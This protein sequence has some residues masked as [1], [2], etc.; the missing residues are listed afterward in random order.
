MKKLQISLALFIISI[1]VFAQTKL[2][3]LA[4]QG[5][6]IEV[7]AKTVAVIKTDVDSN[8][9]YI[10]TQK[11][12]A[13]KLNKD[14]ITCNIGFVQWVLIFSPIWLFVIA[15]FLVRKKLK[16]FS[17]KEFLTEPELPK[18][19]IPNP[20]YTSEKL[21]TLATNPAISGV[22]ATLIPPTIEV[23]ASTE[24]P[25]SSSR[26]IALITSA[27]TWIIVLCLSCFFLYQYMR[28]NKPPELS[29]LSSV[30]LALGI[31]VVPYAFNKMSAAM[32]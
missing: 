25:K 26:Y 1:T 8:K 27:L 18:K 19:T 7:I 22:L 2:D 11:E 30:L 10:N 6:Q 20:E 32:K 21:N 23:T 15:L 31:G 3:T 16:N 17:L 24:F 29:G 14:C 5:Q 4:K 9:A 28:T 12:N 13:A